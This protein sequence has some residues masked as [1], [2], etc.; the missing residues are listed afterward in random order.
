MDGRFSGLA[1]LA[2]LA[3]AQVF[4]FWEWLRVHLP[5]AVYITFAWV[6]L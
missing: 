3:M 2:A 1:F 4:V 5:V 6:E